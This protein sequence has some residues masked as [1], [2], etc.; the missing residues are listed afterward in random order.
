MNLWKLSKDEVNKHSLK[1]AN[2]DQRSPFHKPFT[3]ARPSQD[4]SAS[5]RWHEESW[6][7]SCSFKIPCA[8]S[9]LGL[10]ATEHI[11]RW[12]KQAAC[13]DQENAKDNIYAHIHSNSPC[14]YED[15][16]TISQSVGRFQSLARDQPV[17]R[18]LYD[19]H[20]I[21]LHFPQK[22]SLIHHYS[23]ARP[24]KNEACSAPSSVYV[25]HCLVGYE[26]LWHTKLNC[27]AFT[28]LEW[29]G[30]CRD[31]RIS[32]AV[33][34]VRFIMQTAEEFEIEGKGAC[35]GRS[36]TLHCFRSDQG[37]SDA[38][39]ASVGMAALGKLKF[40]SHIHKVQPMETLTSHLLP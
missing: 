36:F 5:W 24:R 7:V 31:R 15:Y 6:G 14:R 29:P 13:W 23:Q 16:N 40:L 32:G 8:L 26:G 39:L 35:A 21:I 30:A 20:I 18:V 17:Y 22:H 3:F 4:I 2:V 12:V 1:L 27:V 37:G 9:E 28:I 11:D 19:I 38:P 34:D 25:K 33:L 10:S